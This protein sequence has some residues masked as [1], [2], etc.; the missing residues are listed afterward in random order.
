MPV[1]KNPK[2]EAFCQARSLGRTLDQAYSDAGYKPSRAHAARLAANG[3]ITDRIKELQNKTAE[4]YE[5]TAESV[6][7]EL[8]EA[9][10]FARKCKVPSAMVAGLNVKARLFGLMV[11]HAS[12]Q[13]THSYSSMTEEELRFELAALNAEARSLKPGV[14]H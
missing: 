6:A 11:E 5:A 12:V 10:K 14:Q 4:L 13:V 2:Q 8:D 9:I 7:R 1:L 3:S